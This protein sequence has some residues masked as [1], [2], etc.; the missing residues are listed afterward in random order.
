MGAILCSYL[1]AATA[2]AADQFGRDAD[3]S[4]AYGWPASAINSH[5]LHDL[6]C[7]WD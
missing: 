5:P 4:E 1:T 3:S 2:H 6:W 7:R